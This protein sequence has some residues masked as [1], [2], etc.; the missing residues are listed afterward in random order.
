MFDNFWKKNNLVSRFEVKKF[1]EKY[2][3]ND[4]WHHQDKKRGGLGYGWVHYSLIRLINPKNVLC[5]GS[6]FGFIPA[7]C[8]L[9]CRDNGQ[10]VVDFV[11]AAYDMDN[12][13]KLAG[14]HWGGGGFWK[15]CNEKHYF[16]N[17]GLEKN[18]SLKV[19]T[20]KEYANKNKNKKYGYIHIDG[21]HSYDGV[22]LDFDLFWPRLDKGGFLAI[23]DVFSP[24]KDGNVYGTRKFW[25]ELKKTK[26]Y[27]LIEIR[28]NPGVGIIQKN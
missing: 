14:K 19:M 18:I 1:I 17:F 11:D 8:A 9:A 5:V 6:K 16:G 3:R 22:R 7:V 23:H 10:G 28:E 26:K 12:Y 24:D 27:K 21:D 13:G 25:E 15:K 2:A 20:S 4:I